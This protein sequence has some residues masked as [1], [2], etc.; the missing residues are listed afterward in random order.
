[1]E[2]KAVV[3]D[4]VGENCRYDDI[5]DIFTYLAFVCCGFTK[6]CNFDKLVWTKVFADFKIEGAVSE[7]VCD[8]CFKA[9]NSIEADEV[10]EEEG[11][12]LCNCVF[13]LG[14]GLLTLLNNTRLH[15]KRGGNYGLLGLNDCGKIILMRAIANEQVEGFLLMELKT[16]F[17][18]HGIG[19]VELEC[20]WFSCDY[21]LDE[22]VI[23]VMFD[24]GETSMEK[25]EEELTAVGFKR[26]DKLDMTLA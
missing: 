25:M 13:T 6:Y 10:E 15:L 23:K 1:V 12:D 4:P 11:E 18:E 21:L 19:E 3:K 16:A 5:D 24:A 8:L 9:A 26:G 20:D 2:V 17:V 7:K 22:L 14:Y